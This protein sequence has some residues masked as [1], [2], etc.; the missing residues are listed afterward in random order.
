[1]TLGGT[2]YIHSSEN[3]QTRAGFQVIKLLQAHHPQINE[4]DSQLNDIFSEETLGLGGIFIKYFLKF[5][6]SPIHYISNFVSQSLC[7]C[8]DNPT[9]PQ[10]FSRNI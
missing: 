10:F 4:A 1:M 7:I 3:A 5:L 2:V 9:H 6:D 8:L